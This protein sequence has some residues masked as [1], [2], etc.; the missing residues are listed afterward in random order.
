MIV[1]FPGLNGNEWLD[2]RRFTMMEMKNLGFGQ[3]HWEMIIQV[4]YYKLFIHQLRISL[5]NIIIL[6][7]TPTV[8]V[9]IVLISLP[10]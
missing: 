10:M 1:G 7:E 9:T 2:Q 6:T 8:F 3:S 4:T 5:L